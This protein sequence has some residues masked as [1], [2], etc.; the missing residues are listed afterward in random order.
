[1]KVQRV[2]HIGKHGLPPV[3]FSNPLAGPGG[4]TWGNYGKSF[5]FLALDYAGKTGSFAGFCRG[6]VIYS[7]GE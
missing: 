2:G 1:M 7:A 4:S 6:R 3:G 5:N